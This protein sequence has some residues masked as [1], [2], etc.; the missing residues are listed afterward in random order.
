MLIRTLEIVLIIIIISFIFLQVFQISEI[1]YNYYRTNYR[2]LERFLRGRFLI[3]FLTES[4]IFSDGICNL[5]KNFTYL[6]EGK[7]DLHS[8]IENRELI[9]PS[10]IEIVN[11]NTGE[12]IYEIGN[13]TES[14]ISFSRVCNYNGNLLKIQVMV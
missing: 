10:K 11:L 4:S 5:N 12:K 8:L 9:T 1:I 13:R 2:F 7:L 3:K 6:I 14:Y